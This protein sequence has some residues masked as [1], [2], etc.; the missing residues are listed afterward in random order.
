MGLA[1]AATE[2]EAV[3]EAVPEAAL[4]SLEAEESTY[5]LV[6]AMGPELCW[7]H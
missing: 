6:Q 7:L 1:R 3:Q 2:V 5:A 4:E